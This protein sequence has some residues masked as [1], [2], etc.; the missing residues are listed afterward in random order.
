[1]NSR[2][3]AKFLSGLITGDFLVGVWLY[4]AGDLPMSFLGF[5]ITNAF[6]PW[7]LIIDV[8]LFAILV[9]YAWFTKPRKK[10]K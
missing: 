3:I 4:Q 10:M 7:W 2:E 6:V 8:V 9:Y 1:M 5:R